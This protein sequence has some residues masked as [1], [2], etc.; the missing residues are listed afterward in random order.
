MQIT[1]MTDPERAEESENLPPSRAILRPMGKWIVGSGLSV[2]IVAGAVLLWQLRRGVL[3]Y[4]G[5]LG[6]VIEWRKL[7]R[8][9]WMTAA[10]V[11]V[12]LLLQLV[13]VVIGE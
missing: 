8:D 11:V 6:G 12:S 13:G 9:Q 1:A 2:G 10:L 5:T 7:Q 4:Q 3:R